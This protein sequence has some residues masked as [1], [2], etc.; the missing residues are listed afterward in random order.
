MAVSVSTQSV[1]ILVSFIARFLFIRLLSEEY[2]GI[3]GLFSNIL[4]VLSMVE[5]GLGDAL[6]FAFYKPMQER[7]EDELVRLFLFSKR[8]YRILALTVASI[9]IGIS[10]FLEV[11]AEDVPQIPENFRVIFYLF[12]INTVISYLM[13]Y[14]R[15]VLLA[16]QKQY[17]ISLTTQIVYIVQQILQIAALAFT[18]SYYLYLVCQVL[19]TLAN[20]VWISHIATK[21]YPFFRKD[22]NSQLE[23]SKVRKI[24]SDM[25]SLSISKIAGVIANGTDS[26]IISKN[27]GLTAVGLVSN[28]TMIINAV[29]GIMWQALNALVG[30]I[31]NFNVDSSKE[32]KNNVFSEVF[33]L[34]YWMYSVACVCL[35]TLLNPFVELWLG[36]R[37]VLDGYIVFA[38]VFIVYVSG[39]NFPAY[40][41]RVTSGI[42]REVR[43]FHLASAILNLIMSVIL[44]FRWGL[45]GVFI[46]TSASRLL[47]SEIADGYLVSKRILGQSYLK[48]VTSYLVCLALFCGNIWLCS[49]VTD[50]I[51][52]TGI[53]GFLLKAGSCLLCSNLLLFSMLGRTEAFNRIW[54]RFWRI[55][56]KT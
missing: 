51:N 52:M 48:Y 56:R 45:F 7:N 53:F 36:S 47:T 25:K 18:H 20:N 19:C 12:L 16:D 32:E 40:S 11:L 8:I 1:N 44:V 43:W 2:L 34:A 50:Q 37:F 23:K 29:N 26:I 46:A 42:F 24:W 15:M 13:A 55:L 31:G 4:T 5:L 54:R 41:F 10:F 49:V 9:G 3:G 30:S 6:T 28:Y 14:K 27:I 33:L 39:V 35:I 17:I 21:H 22:A 38:L